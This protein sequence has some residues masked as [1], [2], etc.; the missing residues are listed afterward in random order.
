LYAFSGTSVVYGRAT[1]VVVATGAQT[2]LGKINRMMSE[3]VQITTPLLRQ[4]DS[5]GK[6][7][8]VAIFVITVLFFAVGYYF[9]DYALDE[10][11]MAVI[12]LAVAAIPEGLPAI[13][14][15]TLAI[16]VQAMAKR[17]AII[18]RLPSVE[19][20]GSVTVICSDKTGTL[21]RNEMTARSV[22]T[23]DKNYTVEGTG[24]HPEG[25]IK[26]DDIPVSISDDTVL[27]ELIKTV[28]VCND[29]DLHED[30]GNWSMEGDPTEGALVTLGYKA[31]LGDFNPRRIDYI[32]FES[33]HQFMATLNEIDEER[34]IFL[35]GAPEKILT[36]CGHNV[37]PGEIPI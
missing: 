2:E 30:N 35:K 5:F 8:S 25:R 14:T 33:E 20:L 13:M 24:Y 19:T 29:A 27:R 4:I 37:Q 22:V 31:G 36:L 9:R 6:T 17:N 16:G 32:P 26:N 28:R 15:I 11:F 3:V 10:L 18:R 34:F 12:S 23:A 21:T 7:L 1:G